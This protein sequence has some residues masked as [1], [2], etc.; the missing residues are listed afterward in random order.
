MLKVGGE[1]APVV[2]EEV[3]GGLL[4]QLDGMWGVVVVGGCVRRCWL[5]GRVNPVVTTAD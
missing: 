1:Q 3:G 5:D 4:R 2:E